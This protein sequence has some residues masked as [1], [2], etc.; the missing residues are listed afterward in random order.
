ML[1]GPLCVG[2]ALDHCE[3]FFQL[4][5][6]FSLFMY[7]IDQTC[8]AKRQITNAATVKIQSGQLR[9]FLTVR[10]VNALPR[11]HQIDNV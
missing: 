4:I 1:L 8:S 6:L 3:M 5:I 7:N 11:N 9:P 2:V 10:V